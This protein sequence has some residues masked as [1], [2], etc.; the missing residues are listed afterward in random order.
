ML[1]TR[2]GS[3]PAAPPVGGGGGWGGAVAEGMTNYIHSTLN[4]YELIEYSN[5]METRI[6]ALIRAVK[7]TNPKS[8]WTRDHGIH[9]VKQQESCLPFFLISWRDPPPSQIQKLDL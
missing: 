8:E 7:N 6:H 5:A 9:V 2:E 1:P 4:L 3:S